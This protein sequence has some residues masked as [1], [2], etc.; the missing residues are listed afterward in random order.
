MESY[1][2]IRPLGLKALDIEDLLGIVELWDPLKQRTAANSFVYYARH[3][4]QN[5][6][7]TKRVEVFLKEATSRP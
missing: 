6:A 7:L 1:D 2:R 3:V 4:E 5:S